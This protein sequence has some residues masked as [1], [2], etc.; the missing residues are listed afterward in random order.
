DGL[1]FIPSK[2][3]RE[4]VRR[5]LRHAEAG[6]QANPLD[7]SRLQILSDSLSN[8]KVFQGMRDNLGS[9][10]IALLRSKSPVARWYAMQALE[11]TTGA[12]RTSTTAMKIG[13]A[14]CRERV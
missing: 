4:S 1:D 6:T 10:A 2:E 9:T 14:S 3:V 11:N 5:I 13:R 12:Y 7:E 8:T